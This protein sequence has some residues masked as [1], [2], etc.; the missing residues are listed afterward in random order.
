MTKVL[1]TM[2]AVAFAAAGCVERRLTVISEPPAARVYINGEYAGETPLT[3]P[4]VHHGTREIHVAKDGYQSQRRQEDIRSPIY[5]RFPVDFFFEVLYPGR[6]TD[7]R[8]TVVEL[9]KVEFDPDTFLERAELLRA[10]TE[11]IPPHPLKGDAGEQ[12]SPPK[13]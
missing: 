5:Q 13:E 10:M 12:P 11:A 7:H 6:L 3:V 9:R 8:L 1:L 2:L 4:F